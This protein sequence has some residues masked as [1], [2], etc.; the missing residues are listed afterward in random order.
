LSAERQSRAP[1][2]EIKEQLLVADATGCGKPGQLSIACKHA[3]AGYD[4]GYRVGAASAADGARNGRCC[5]GYFAI[6]ARLPIRNG[7]KGFPYALLETG[8]RGG[9]RKVEVPKCSGKV[10]V[11]LF[12]GFSKERLKAVIAPLL[13]AC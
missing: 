12:A 6:T 11:Q 9:E 10:G 1:G 5:C 7:V 4:D 2:F 8:T 13:R 3:M